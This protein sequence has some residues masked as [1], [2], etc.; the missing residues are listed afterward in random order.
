MN[1]CTDSGIAARTWRA[2]WT[3]ISSTTDLPGCEAPLDL[4]AQRPVAVAAVGRVLQELAV[5]GPAVELLAVEEVVV[6]AVHLALA[7]LPGR[8]RD[9]QLQAR[10][11]L[12]AA[13]R[14]ASPCR[15]PR[16]R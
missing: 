3:S 1:T 5:A 2:P 7:G 4:R 14:S 8:G 16:A 6:A 12:A 13:R 9:R 15:P 10:H 11:P